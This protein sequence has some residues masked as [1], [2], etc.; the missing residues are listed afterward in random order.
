MV[1]I[2][3]R[4]TLNGHVFS[5]V[6]IKTIKSLDGVNS[7]ITSSNDARITKSGIFFHKTKIDEL[8][9]LWNILIGQMSFVGPRPDVIGYA[10]RLQ[11]KDRISFPVR[12]GITDPAQLGYKNEEDIFVKQEDMVKYTIEVIWPDKVANV[13]E[14]ILEIIPFSRTLISYGK[15]L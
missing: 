13:I 7:T 3:K 8:R 2:Q 12:P 5:I 14:Y 9:Q 4:V 10:D 6:I 11:G 15:Q 1:F